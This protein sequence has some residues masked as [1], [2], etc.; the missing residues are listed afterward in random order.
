VFDGSHA[1]VRDPNGT[2]EVPDQMLRE[3]ESGL[4]RDT[5]SVL[6]GAVD[7][8]VRV[9][10]LPDARDD[11][12]VVRQALEFS[13]ADFEPMVMYVDATTGLVAKQSYVANGP[14]RPLVEE[15]FTDYRNVEGVQINFSASVRVGGQPALDRTVTDAKINAPLDP[16][17][18]RR[19]G[20]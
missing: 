2:H 10:R 8:R 6:L 12:G 1:W 15:S 19:P 5:I 7:G 16:A 20:S 14:G 17:L 9:R 11:A 3:F 4:K 13:G 18:F